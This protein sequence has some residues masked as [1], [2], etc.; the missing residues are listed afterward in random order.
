MDRADDRGATYADD[1]LGLVSRERHR[2][3]AHR[4]HTLPPGGAAPEKGLQNTIKTSQL[5]T[6]TELQ[7]SKDGDARW[8]RTTDTIGLEGRYA[9]SD[10]TW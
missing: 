10:D 8:R 6:V 4:S 3:H 2:P 1:S 7:K 5:A 9:A